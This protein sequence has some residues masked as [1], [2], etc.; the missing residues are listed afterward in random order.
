[1]RK[2][3]KGCKK[4]TQLN[5]FLKDPRAKEQ[6]IDVNDDKTHLYAIFAYFKY[7]E[8]KDV[9]GEA[10]KARFTRTLI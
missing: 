4:Y 6:I 2:C 10:C 8:V 9:D 7:L 3:W 1:V 5:A